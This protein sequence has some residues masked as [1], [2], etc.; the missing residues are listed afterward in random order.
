MVEKNKVFGARCLSCFLLPWES[1][2]L[3]LIDFLLEWHLVE[4]FKV[5]HSF[6]TFK[7]HQYLITLFF[8]Y[9]DVELSTRFSNKRV[10]ITEM[11]RINQRSAS[12]LN[13]GS[14]ERNLLK[15]L[16]LP[17]FYFFKYTQAI[18]M[19]KT[20]HC[21]TWHRTT[22]SWRICRDIT[23]FEKCTS[24]VWEKSSCMKE[25][26]EICFIHFCR[27]SAIL[28]SLA[29]IGAFFVNSKGCACNVEA[30]SC[31]EAQKWQGN[32]TDDLLL[33]VPVQRKCSISMY[34]EFFLYFLHLF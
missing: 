25:K 28:Q 8:L 19:Q 4:K 9:R 10:E 27:S 21:C 33:H 30:K 18:E 22:P 24:S 26:Q 29:F 15:M 2:D 12:M 7:I 11:L 23:V 1:I 13:S 17:P 16:Q 31:F 3:H 5:T 34:G 14:W 6:W 20:W 32:G